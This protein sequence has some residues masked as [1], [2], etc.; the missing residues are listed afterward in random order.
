MGCLLLAACSK[1]EVETVGPDPIGFGVYSGRAVSKADNSS[2]V[3]GTTVTGIPVGKSIGVF[4]YFHAGDPSTSTSGTWS[5][6]ATP[7]LMDN[8]PVTSGDSDG[9]SFTYSP[10]RY[11]P[12]S[13]YDRI[14]FIGYYPYSAYGSTDT[15]IVPTVTSGFGSYAFSVNTDNTKQVDFMLSDLAANQS[16]AAGVHTGAADGEVN[17]T[18]HHVLSNVAVRI[19]TILSD[20]VSSL[21]I[22]DIKVRNMKNKGVCKPSFTGTPAS[23]GATST[24]FT[25]SSL[26][27]DADFDLGNSDGSATKDI[28]L[29]IPQSFEFNDDAVVEIYYDYVV[30]NNLGTPVTYTGNKKSMQLNLCKDSGGNSV[31]RWEMN[32]KYVYD[33]TLSLDQ[34]LF[35]SSISDWTYLS[36]DIDSN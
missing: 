8:V 20:N 24:T 34:I 4:G 14:S 26:V 30:P 1:N 33:I 2:Y 31:T 25:W 15:G 11:W 18:F 16:K 23:N 32:K 9:S 36:E 27:H 29:M 22:T 19:T 28:L 3:D 6:A 5:A 12:L 17:L 35:T 10:A 21:T 7:T 13:Q